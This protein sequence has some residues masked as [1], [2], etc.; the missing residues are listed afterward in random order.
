M[1]YLSIATVLIIND[2]AVGN[3][4]TVSVCV[5][6]CVWTPIQGFCIII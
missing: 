1:G 3:Q 4:S 5:C 2:C 6:V